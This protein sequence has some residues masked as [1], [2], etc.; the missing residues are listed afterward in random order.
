L[1]FAGALVQTSALGTAS[2]MRARVMAGVVFRKTRVR[3]CTPLLRAGPPC[4]W[5]RRWSRSTPHRSMRW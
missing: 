3:W 5:S 2:C 1:P 4:V